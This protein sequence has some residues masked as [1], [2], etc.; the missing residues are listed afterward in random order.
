[1]ASGAASAV[2]SA[3]GEHMRKGGGDKAE[4]FIDSLFRNEGTAL[5]EQKMCAAS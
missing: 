5:S 2:T 3:A 4:Y 1:M